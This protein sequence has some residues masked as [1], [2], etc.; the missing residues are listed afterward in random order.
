MSSRKIK[1]SAGLLASTVSFLFLASPASAADECGVAPPAGG[2]V[3]CTPGQNPYSNGIFY[4]APSNLTI[5]LQNGVIV[6]SSGSLNPGVFA[7]AT[8]QT[9]AL[10]I[11][12]ATNTSITTSDSGANGAVLATNDGAIN[13]AL[14]RITTSGA[15]ANGVFGSS[16]T[17][18]TSISAN[19]ITTSGTSA[20]GVEANTNSGNI[21]VD[22]GTIRASG[23][24]AIGV[25]ARSDVANVSVIADDIAT[26]SLTGGNGITA[27]TGGIGT[28]TI[29]SG[30][31]T[32]F[33]TNATGIRATNNTGTVQ[34][35][36]DR[37]TTTGT[38]AAEGISIVTRGSAI[39][40][41][42]IISTRG[43]GANGI[44]V[45]APGGAN[46][47]Y[48]SVS[49]TGDNAVGVLVPQGAFFFGP[50]GTST[51]TLTGGSVTT[52][53]ANADGIRAFASTGSVTANLSGTIST[54]GNNSRGIVASGPTGVSITGPL[55]VTTAGTTSNAVDLNSVGPITFSNTGGSIRTT[56]A[57]SNGINI[58]GGSGN[59][60]VNTG[61]VSA[62]GAGSIG[63]LSS[64]LG[65][66]GTC[67]TSTINVT[68]NVNA[69]NS[70][71]CGNQT[72]AVSAGSTA[73]TSNP[74]G[75]TIINNATGIAT[76]TINGAVNAGAP[77]NLALNNNG[78]SSVTTIASTGSLT[79][80]IDTTV[81]ADTLTN[82]GNFTTSGIND[83][84]TGTDSFANNAT[85]IFN[86]AGNASLVGLETFT[87]AGRIN[88]NTFTLSG[89]SPFTSTGTIDTNGSA[90]LTGF[91][92]FT[93][94]G[95]L[96]LAAGTFTAPA[97]VFTNSGTILADEGASTILNQTSFAN[98]GTLDL[99]DGAT[100][101]VL[102]INSAFVGSGGSNLLIDFD[103]TTADRLVI[104][105]AASGSTR[106]DANYLSTGLLNIG[107]ILVVDTTSSTANAFTLGTVSGNTSTLVGYSLIQ[108]GAD[109]FL[110]ATPNQAAFSPVAVSDLAT[111]IW[112]QSADEV[113][114]QTDLPAVTVGASVWGQAYYSRDK[115]G[116][117]QDAVLGGT[118]FGYDTRNKT[119]RYGLQGGVDYGF[120]G[121]RIG[122]T[123]GYGRAKADNDL[124]SAL[125][126][127]GYNI[128]LYG[129]FGGYTGFHG[130][131]LI[132]HDR[133]KLRFTDGAFDGEGSR[134][135]ANG[136]DGSLG[137]RFGTGATNFDL[138]V[139]AS[140]VRT[141]INDVNA[142]GFTYDYG[143]N[144][145]TRGRAGVRA[146]FAAGSIAPYIDATV[147]HEFENGNS[148]RL[149][150]GLNNYDLDSGGK[151]T[152]GRIE[153]GLTGSAGPGPI[154]AAWADFGD[155]KGFG[156]RAG[157]RF[158]GAAR[159]IEAAAP[160]PPPP[161]P[162][163]VA[164]ATQTCIDGSVILATD[165]CPIA[166][167]PPAP[168]EPAPERG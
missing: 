20:N 109:Y 126:A 69:V 31:I 95:T 3:T 167:P 113:R 94:A 71:A 140:R 129:Q 102:T 101:D 57:N 93:N 67:G 78:T 32:T 92:A 4:V 73:S 37:I 119:R 128:G 96:D 19:S 43:V 165:A 52:T 114:N 98:S 87:N 14:D 41:G 100:G 112:Y 36:S 51:V 139:G 163:E 49:T 121:A 147:H 117:R 80:R 110:T 38:G 76:T 88:L 15:N 75:T 68:G 164:P 23:S 64:T 124:S 86:L 22:V 47:T 34:V 152:W 150:D 66:V 45:Q 161:P 61:A 27:G 74:A 149:F 111:S 141:K 145:S 115:I 91:T 108:N 103:Q 12:G 158:G 55:T 25:S 106:V 40:D 18:T 122:L 9:G 13:I 46:I 99:Q 33:G 5:V 16:A 58:V 154:L 84:G 50:L 118:T 21:F 29:D 8:T 77:G 120:G 28:V 162:V 138:K 26:S 82:A 132:K 81:G 24:G 159:V 134:L 35:F 105:G 137:Y 143:T 2:T 156:A 168:P 90:G 155:K 104:N 130:S 70:D 62:I 144:K 123:G 42:G 136:I 85:G 131:A 116:D 59:L 142:F 157:F 60:L 107:G 127:T 153:A 17:G 83:F 54:A 166:P 146:T 1:L 6:N 65:A 133:Y 97:G 7:I 148:V 11:S 89:T 63:V 72:I 151:G 135:R 79:G 10:T 125:K 44:Q 48:G 56:G 53:G 39:V 160:P 30:I